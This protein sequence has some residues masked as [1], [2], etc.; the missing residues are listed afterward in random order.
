MGD[1]IY[2]SFTPLNGKSPIQP[3]AKLH[4]YG[5]D[6]KSVDDLYHDMLLVSSESMRRYSEI[7]GC[8]YELSIQSMTEYD[9]RAVMFS[10]TEILFD[11]KYDKYDRIAVFDVDVVANTV[12]DIFEQSD[13]EFYGVLESE[14]LNDHKEYQMYM[15]FGCPWDGWDRQHVYE[16]YKDK[17]ELHGMEM[18]HLDTGTFGATRP[19]QRLHFQGGMGVWSREARIKARRK[20][21]SW[22]EWF[23][24]NPMPQRLL[25]PFYDDAWLSANL[26]HH[27]FDMETLDFTWLNC[28]L[29]YRED[30]VYKKMQDFKF[31]HFV[32]YPFNKRL[33]LIFAMESRFPLVKDY[34]N[35]S[36]RRVP[37]RKWEGHSP[38]RYV[39]KPDHDASDI[40]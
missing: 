2:Q 14:W 38:M 13:K 28:P 8:D 17:Y 35:S 10:W 36:E 29:Q 18:K 27:E 12:E 37:Y 9:T 31:N 7:I 39:S 33:M 11:E 23:Y 24:I 3:T 16:T 32:G 21:S 6:L 30:L 34:Q 20:F 22:R 5:S 19:S 15:P 40:L 26:Q 1:L 25:S 4:Q